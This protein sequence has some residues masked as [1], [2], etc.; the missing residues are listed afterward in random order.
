MNIVRYVA[1]A[2]SE[3]AYVVVPNGSR[4]CAVV[5]PGA[6]AGRVVG[7]IEREDLTVRYILVTH[8]HADHTGAVAGVKEATDALFAAHR[9]DAEQIVHP[10]PWMTRDTL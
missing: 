5:D 7:D 3:N 2:L 9:G 8:G 6:E 1:G 4:E 10:L